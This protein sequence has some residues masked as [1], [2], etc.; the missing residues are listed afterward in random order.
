VG[1]FPVLTDH[2]PLLILLKQK[3]MALSCEKCQFDVVYKPGKLLDAFVTSSSDKFIVDEEG[4]HLETKKVL[5]WQML[6]KKVMMGI[7]RLLLQMKK[8][9]WPCKFQNFRSWKSTCSF[10]KHGRKKEKK[11]RCS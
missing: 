4:E 10:A 5:L 3:K 7:Q 1:Q 6:W 2:E 11:S 8:V 9:C